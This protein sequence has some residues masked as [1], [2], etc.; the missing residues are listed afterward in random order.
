MLGLGRL[1]LLGA[2]KSS[3]FGNRR[4]TRLLAGRDRCRPLGALQPGYVEPHKHLSP[5]SHHGDCPRKVAWDRVVWAGI[6]LHLGLVG[7]RFRVLSRHDMTKLGFEIVVGE[8]TR[9]ANP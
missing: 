2:V 4:F 1:A 7:M 5:F 9:F 3:T 6:G 8:T